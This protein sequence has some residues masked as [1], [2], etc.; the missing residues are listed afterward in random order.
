MTERS[1]NSRKIVQYSKGKISR[2]SINSSWINRKSCLFQEKQ[3]VAIQVEMKG[4]IFVHEVGTGPKIR[5]IFR[6]KFD[7]IL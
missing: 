6:R 1:S 4:K 2:T 5:E 3:R 7:H